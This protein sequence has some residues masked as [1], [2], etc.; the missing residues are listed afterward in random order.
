MSV[1]AEAQRG[2]VPPRA[3][4]RPSDTRLVG[5]SIPGTERIVGDPLRRSLRLVTIAW[6]YG[7]FWMA[8]TTGAPLT[9]LAQ[10][11]GADDF[12][13]SLLAAAPYVSVLLQ[14]PGS[15]IVDWLGRRKAFFIWT[16]TGHRAVYPVIGLLPWV[17]PGHA[18]ASALVM[19]FL[20][21]V[22]M[23][24]GN[25]GGGAWANWMADL[26][27]PRVRGKYFARRGR[28]GIIVLLITGLSVGL[29]LDGANRLFP[30]NPPGGGA[31]YLIAGLPPLIVLISVIF[32]IAGLAGM[33]DIL[34]FRNVEEPAMDPP[35]RESL[36]E[37]LARPIRDRQF[38]AYCSYFS[39]WNFAVAFTATF[40]WVY[41]LNFADQLARDGDT[42][43]WLNY[44]NLAGVIVLPA[45]YQIG[46]FLGYPMWGAAV[47][48]FGRKPVLLISSTIHTLTWAIWLFLTPQLVLWLVPM[49]ILGGLM[50]GGQD[51]ANFNMMMGFNRKGG[52]GYQALGSVLFS[53]AGAVG[54][55]MAGSLAKTLSGVQ[56]VILGRPFNHYAILIAIGMLVKMGADFVLLPY[57]QDLKAKPTK[58]TVRFVVAN[59]QGNLSTLTTLIFTPIKSLP[60]GARNQLRTWR[61]LGEKIINVRQN[62]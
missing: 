44:R 38:M 32:V 62:D 35:I 60:V 3:E 46:Q 42:A 31:G 27:P 50:G 54:C 13:F 57:I 17:M 6:F 56:L 26:V 25:M 24:L 10:Y 49:Q 14:I 47:D 53:L 9:R 37:R 58:Q 7:A 45:S 22:S 19:V 39:V 48:K 41:F 12:M 21:L 1:S 34:T 11:L 8:A 30:S 18:T 55:F 28:L 36:F 29:L 61:R 59:L 15:L 16:V 2:Q 40:W 43:W 33:M 51:I 5:R 23:S 20:L 52:P 4:A